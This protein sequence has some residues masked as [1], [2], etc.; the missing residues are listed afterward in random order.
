MTEGTAGAAEPAHIHAKLKDLRVT[1]EIRAIILLNQKR[2]Q[3]FD[4]VFS[5]TNAGQKCDKHAGQFTGGLFGGQNATSEPFCK[6]DP[7]RFFHWSFV[8]RTTMTSGI[9]AC[10]SASGFQYATNACS[11]GR[12]YISSLPC[13]GDH[14]ANRPIVAPVSPA[15]RLLSIRSASCP[16]LRVSC[17]PPQLLR[18]DGRAKSR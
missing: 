7:L 18:R 14:R 5:K 13:T 10:F 9:T 15:S 11:A 8:V 17:A 6:N 16:V 3:R 2:R 1:I 12:C 4:G